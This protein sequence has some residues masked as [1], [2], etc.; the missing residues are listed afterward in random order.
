MI[1]IKIVNVPVMVVR[2]LIGIVIGAVVVVAKALAMYGNYNIMIMRMF[3][4]NEQEL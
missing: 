4:R 2:I 3:L 1:V